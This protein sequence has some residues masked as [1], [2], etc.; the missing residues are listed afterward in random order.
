MIGTDK[1]NKIEELAEEMY[2][3]YNKLEAEVQTLHASTS[4]DL[5]SM[6]KSIFTLNNNQ[7]SDDYNLDRIEEVNWATIA[8]GGRIDH[9]NTERGAGRNW[10]DM[11]LHWVGRANK[12]YSKFAPAVSHS[13]EIVLSSGQIQPGRCFAFA[14]KGNITVEFH[15]PLRPASVVLEHAP[16]LRESAPQHFDVVGWMMKDSSKDSNLSYPAQKESLLGS[17]KFMNDAS[18]S[19]KFNVSSGETDY[20]DKMTFSFQTNWGADHTCVYRIKVY[21]SIAKN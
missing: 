19:Q 11:I 15:E 18:P 13:P 1:S 21:G 2:R 7:D 16:V 17:F 8:L 20:F 10:H 5:T 14:I 4:K 9:F 6:Q 3:K 12:R